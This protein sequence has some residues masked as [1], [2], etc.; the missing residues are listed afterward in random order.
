MIEDTAV[1]EE[2]I[3]EILKESPETED[4]EEGLKDP[5]NGNFTGGYSS[6]RSLILENI[7]NSGVDSPFRG[8][9]NRIRMRSLFSDFPK[10]SPDSKPPLYTL[11]DSEH[12]GCP[13]LHKL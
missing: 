5:S 10:R 7:A 11:K 1:V 13:S 9:L 2:N 8:N 3:L 12:R 6:V 4:T